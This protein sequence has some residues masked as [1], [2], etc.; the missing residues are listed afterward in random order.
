[1]LNDFSLPSS[2]PCGPYQESWYLALVDAQEKLGFHL[3]FSGLS[4]SNGFRES[5]QVSAILFRKET[6]AGLPIALKEVFDLKKAVSEDGGKKIRV[7]ACEF[8]DDRTKGRV[9]SKGNTVEWDLTISKRRSEDI[10]F[11]L[12]PA[13]FRLSKFSPGVRLTSRPDLVVQGWVSLNGDRA[14]VRDTAGAQNFLTGLR[15]CQSWITVQCDTFENDQG[16]PVSFVF[17]GAEFKN[18]ILGIFPSPT[19]SSLHLVYAGKT[20]NFDSAREAIRVKSHRTLNTWTI[21][22]E[23]GDLTFRASSTFKHKDFAGWTQEDTRGAVIYGAISVFADLEV[24]V[25]REGKLQVALKAPHR[26]VIETFSRKKN[27]YVPHLI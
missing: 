15:S 13:P 4:S 11:N 5:A 25:Y 14:E 3:R 2:F 26:A 10:G 8:S 19:I 12:V 16:V 6:G 18:R 7:G 22:A 21:E 24:Q 27:P 23:R 9:Q 17:A 1:M 20:Y